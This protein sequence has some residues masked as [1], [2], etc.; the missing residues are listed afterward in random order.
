VTK[1][2]NPI[3]LFFDGR[4]GFLDAG[5]IYIGQS[6]TDPTIIANQIEVFWDKARIIPAAQP[7]RTLGG[8]IVQGLNLGLPYVA[9]PDFSLTI[10][11]ANG[12]LITYVPS[13]F[14]LGMT[15][16]QPL[17]SDLSA[18]AGLGTTDFGRGILTLID[19]SALRTLAG[20]GN[21]AILNEATAAQFRSNTADKVLT[22]DQVWGAAV[23][24]ALA[25]SGGNVAVD[26]N[27]GINFMLAMTGG[28]WTLSNP[29]NVKDG[30][31]GKIEISQDA[32]GSRVL[33]YGPNWDFANG[34]APVLSTAANA[35][36]ILYYTGLSDG[37]VFGSLVKARA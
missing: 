31:S 36:D 24:V 10:L 12:N 5:S 28:P 27:A 15:D 32:T 26:L 13:A 25:Q 4:G 23:S 20:L 8:A 17:D 3:P 18:I 30:Q 35:K 9:E 2:V 19:A 6:N 7:L 16:Y 1:L 37:N 33:N 22:T 29:T 21:S 11:D 14:D 34:T